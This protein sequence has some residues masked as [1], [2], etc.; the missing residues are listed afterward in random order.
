MKEKIKNLIPTHVWNTMRHLYVAI[1]HACEYFTPKVRVITYCG[2]DLF[3]NRGNSIIERLKKEEVFE[4]GLCTTMVA[5]LEGRANP[6]LLDIGANLGLISLYVL[7]RMPNVTIHAFEPGPQQSALL[8]KTIQANT[9]SDRIHI[10][11]IALSDKVGKHTFYSHPKRDQA[12]DGLY[13]TGR[14]EK[15]V[16]IEVDTTTLDA[17]W[18]QAGRPHVDA[19]K[20]DTEG[21]EL[22]ILR[23]A[24]EFLEAVQPIVYLEIEPRN[25]KAYPYNEEEL[26]TFL[27]TI[28]FDVF[29]LDG[30]R[31]TNDELKKYMLSH[32]TFVAKRS[33]S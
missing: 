5:S 32:D 23:G 28:G 6:V 25:L 26:I 29:T 21:A 33:S 7:E 19:V 16:A 24:R 17:W 10:N 15:T 20:M 14:G 12:K 30:N 9:L 8:E 18:K 27:E 2:F 22:L 13:D 1:L 4:K 11:K 3:Y 31:V